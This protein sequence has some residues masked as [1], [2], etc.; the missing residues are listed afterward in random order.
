MSGLVSLPEVFFEPYYELRSFELLFCPAC[1]T[2]SFHEMRGPMPLA[3]T[4]A[5][6]VWYWCSY[7]KLQTLKSQLN[8]LVESSLSELKIVKIDMT[9]EA[10][11][12]PAR[13]K[14]FMRSLVHSYRASKLRKHSTV[15]FLAVSTILWVAWLQL[16]WQPFTITSSFG[17]VS[18]IL[19]TENYVVNVKC[20]EQGGE[21]LNPVW[22]RIEKHIQFKYAFPVA[23]AVISL[24]AYLAL[25]WHFL[26][27]LWI[28]PF[29]YAPALPAAIFCSVNDALALWDGAQ[30]EARG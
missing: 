19:M 8:G 3:R 28:I 9:A 4:S 16:T 5:P 27:G 13:V 23:I 6:T 1:K 29:V 12:Y 14:R 21:E 10:N 22:R 11:K 17:L 25:D 20:R 26:K 7:C 18:M 24:A 30:I 15:V 2:R